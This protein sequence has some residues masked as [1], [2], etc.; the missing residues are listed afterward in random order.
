VKRDSGKSQKSVKTMDSEFRIQFS[1]ATF[2]LLNAQRE[3]LKDKLLRTYK[4]DKDSLRFYFLGSN[5][6]R[7]VEHYGIKE[8]IDMEKPTII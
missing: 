7:K 3:I 4:E 2:R 1:N 5:W 8:T 6:K